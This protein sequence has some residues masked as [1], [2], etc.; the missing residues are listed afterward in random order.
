METDAT[1]IFHVLNEIKVALASLERWA[2]PRKI[3]APLYLTGTRAWIRHEPRGVCLIISPWNYPF[4]LAVGP[5]VSAIAAGNNVIIKPSEITPAVSALIR[6]MCDEVFDPAVVSACE[7][8]V[9]VSQALL[10][11]PFDHIFFTGSPAVGKVVMK[12]AAEHLASVTLELGGKSPAIVSQNAKLDD[13]AERIAVGKFLNNGQT[14]IAPD[15][16]L[17]D[18]KIVAKFVAK[19]IES[20]RKLYVGDGALEKSDDYGRIVNEAHFKR[21]DTLIRDAVDRGANV[22]WN[23]KLDVTSRFIHPI[24]MTRVSPDSRL[25]QEEIFGPVLPVISYSNL[26]EALAIINSK[27]KPLALYLF[28]NSKAMREEVLNK[29]SSGTVCLNDCGIQF[30]HHELP[31][32]GVNNSGIGKSHGHYGFLAFSNE[33]A[34]LKQRNGFTAIKAFYPP[35]TGRTKQLMDW[36][37]R[38]F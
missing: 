10:A 6:R 2:A 30:L 20:T 13:A 24:V 26:E 18:E 11:L 4:S 28:S 3:D 17:A 34:V 21:V 22:E 9:A 31:F 16:V 32:G 27:P 25:M 38:L 1:E 36:F 14:C 37:L 5:L 35:F 33:K 15:Y 8:G 12:A 23:G 7:G 29:T 19:L